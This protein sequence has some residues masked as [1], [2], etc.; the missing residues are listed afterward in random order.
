LG[1]LLLAA[2]AAGG[3][4]LHAYDLAETVSAQAGTLATRLTELREERARAGAVEARRTFEAGRLEASY[5]RWQRATELY[6]LAQELGHDPVAIEIARVEVLDA[7]FR[8]DLAREVLER[9]AAR[10]DLGPH[11]AMVTLLRNDVS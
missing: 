10:D 11:R 6:D 5:G 8:S 3:I 4:A 7:T 9:L 1:A 2:L